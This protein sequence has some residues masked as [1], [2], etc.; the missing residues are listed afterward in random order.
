MFPQFCSP[1]YAL[2]EQQQSQQTVQQYDNS[3][4]TLFLATLNFHVPC[5]AILLMNYKKVV[6]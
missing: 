2:C 3:Y 1:D 6:T 4:L 5:G